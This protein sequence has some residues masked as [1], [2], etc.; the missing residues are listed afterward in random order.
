M[1]IL[2]NHISEMKTDR[3]PYRDGQTRNDSEDGRHVSF[4]AFG[5]FCGYTA[6]GHT[7]NPLPVFQRFLLPTEASA[8]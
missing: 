2:W 6:T 8:R 4:I 7:A 1:E 3:I 5:E